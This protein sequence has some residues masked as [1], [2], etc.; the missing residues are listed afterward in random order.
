MVCSSLYRIVVQLICV[1]PAGEML[2]RLGFA[3]QPGMEGVLAITPVA[4][5]QT[6]PYVQITFS[7]PPIATPV[8]A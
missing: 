1:P 6:V 7:A 5:R 4:L 2:A 3:A 8:A